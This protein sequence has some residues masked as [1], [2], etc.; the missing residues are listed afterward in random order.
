MRG[1]SKIP[2][3]DEV[4]RCFGSL[5]DVLTGHPEKADKRWEDWP[6][7]SFI[8]NAGK[9]IGF[10]IVLAGKKIK[11]SDDVEEYERK[12]KSSG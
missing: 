8:A 3:L 11:D 10:G 9:S 4:I 1:G 12:A 6:K 7:N 2:V 5:G